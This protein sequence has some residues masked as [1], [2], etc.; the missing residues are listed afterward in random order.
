MARTI[1]DRP[2]GGGAARRAEAVVRRLR[3]TRLTFDAVNVEAVV[4]L[5]LAGDLEA[6]TLREVGL[7]PERASGSLLAEVAVARGN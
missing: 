1:F 2:I 3:L 4:D 5:R 7:K 6:L